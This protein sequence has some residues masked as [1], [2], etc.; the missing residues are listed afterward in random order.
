M[1]TLDKRYVSLQTVVGQNRRK[2]QTST[3]RAGN[4]RATQILCTFFRPAALFRVCTYWL[5]YYQLLVQYK[6]YVR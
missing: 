2:Q 3:P 5:F 4:I 6:N 1:G